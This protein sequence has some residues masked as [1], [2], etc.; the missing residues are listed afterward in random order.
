MTRTNKK[1]SK[2]KIDLNST[3]QTNYIFKKISLVEV[4]Y[5]KYVNK[6]TTENTQG[7]QKEEI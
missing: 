3:V 7:K 1:M 4:S 5:F 6:K 2:E